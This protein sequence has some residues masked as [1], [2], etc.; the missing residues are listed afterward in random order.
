[1]G[2]SRIFLGHHWLTEVTFAWLLGLAWLALLITAHRIFLAMRTAEA[3]RPSGVKR[4]DCPRRWRHRR[5]RPA[6]EQDRDRRAH[7]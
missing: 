1:M 3:G 6:L 5:S 7:A 4:G 2:F